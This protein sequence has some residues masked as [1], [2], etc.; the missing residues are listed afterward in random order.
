MPVFW[1]IATMLLLA[2]LDSAMQQDAYAKGTVPS[3]ER[4]TPAECINDT[5]VDDSPTRYHLGPLNGV[6]CGNRCCREGALDFP[7]SYG[8]VFL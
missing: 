5:E 8:E 7:Q 1:R 4:T 3:S 6:V 2:L